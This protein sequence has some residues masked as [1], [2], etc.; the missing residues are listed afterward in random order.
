MKKIERKREQTGMGRKKGETVRDDER[1]W[2][3]LGRR[4]G[5]RD[6]ER[7]EAT[8]HCFCAARSLSSRERKN[9]HKKEMRE[10]KGNQSIN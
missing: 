6:A 5:K 8:R 3:T 7:R 4:V 9:V 1:H 10:K 2:G